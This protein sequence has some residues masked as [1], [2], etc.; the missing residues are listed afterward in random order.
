M[1]KIMSLTICFKLIKIDENNISIDLLR[2]VLD[3]ILYF[4]ILLR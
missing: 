3:M 4:L 1:L 2:N